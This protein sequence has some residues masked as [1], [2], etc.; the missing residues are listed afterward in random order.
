MAK[1]SSSKKQSNTIPFQLKP[2]KNSLFSTIAIIVFLLLFVSLIAGCASLF[3][4]EQDTGNTALIPIHGSIMPTGSTS[5]FDDAIASS[6]DI[7]SM[8]ESANNN[9]QIKVIVLD[10]NSGGG[11]PVASAEIARAVKNS[12]KPTIAW[13]RDVGA[14]GAYWVASSADTIVAHELSTT[15]S[16]GV[17][18]SYLEF[19]GL[20][21]EYN[22]SYNR[23]V[24]GYYKDMG[25]PL[26][27]MTPSEERI[28][29]NLLDDMHSVFIS[30][31]AQ[32][33]NMS[34]S[35]VTE[36]AD[37]RV[38]L[39][40]SAKENGLVDVL[41]S[42]SEVIDL[43]QQHVEGDVDF[44][45]YQVEKSFFDMVPSIS[46]TLG[47]SIG[48]GLGKQLTTRSTTTQTPTV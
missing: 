30:N 32:N 20:L 8:I 22:V 45:R 44:R 39:G 42:K 18:A 16:I 34:V 28:Y 1:K 3:M 27:E 46:S 24:S 25:T 12:S 6:S 35:A 15:G 23:Q 5:A 4:P 29:Q 36:L 10:I 38:Y 2:R 47:Q 41:G 9:D 14:S 17:L 19:S 43:A 13:I 21:D 31:V 40:I 33:R 48:V 11:A 7:V 26:K 37:G